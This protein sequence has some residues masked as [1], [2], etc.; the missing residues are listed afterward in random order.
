MG[1][2][3]EK[4]AAAG[5]ALCGEESSPVTVS[6]AIGSG[7]DGMRGQG[8]GG[9]AHS[10]GDRWQ[11]RDAG[12]AAAGGRRGFGATQGRA[13]PHPIQASA[14]RQRHRPRNVP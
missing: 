6:T 1:Q 9:Y 4:P 12:M 10:I 2:P 3:S 11:A 5:E 7:E 13:P 14:P 8:C